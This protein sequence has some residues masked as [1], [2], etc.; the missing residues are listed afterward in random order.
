MDIQGFD[1]VMR[2]L[3]LILP[4]LV[5]QLG[6]LV[7]ALIDLLKPERVTRGPK[8]LWGLIVILINVIGPIAYLAVGR[9]E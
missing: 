4:L 6:L 3:P 8:W 5:V 2:F 9:E 1:Q 7:F